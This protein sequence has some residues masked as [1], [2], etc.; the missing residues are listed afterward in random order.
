MFKKLFVLLLALITVMSIQHKD[1]HLKD[2]HMV[3]KTY[4]EACIHLKGQICARAFGKGE[5]CC[6]KSFW[7]GKYCD[8][9]GCEGDTQ[10]VSDK[11]YNF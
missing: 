7:S 4:K 9:F 2:A 1:H 5:K 6:K 3:K 8:T 10:S 11:D